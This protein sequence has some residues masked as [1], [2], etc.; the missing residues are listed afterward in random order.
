[1]RSMGHGQFLHFGL[2]HVALIA[3]SWWPSVTA[4]SGGQIRRMK[5]AF[6]AQDSDQKRE[7]GLRARSDGEGPQ[8]AQEGVPVRAENQLRKK[9]LQ[10]PDALCLDGSPGGYYFRPGHGAGVTK[11]TIYY[12]GGGWC[13]L[14][15][16]PWPPTK[17]CMAA[18]QEANEQVRGDCATR[19]RSRYGSSLD[20]YHPQVLTHSLARSPHHYTGNE[21]NSTITVASSDPAQNP[22]HDWNTVVVI[23]CVGSSW[24]SHVDGPV[25]AGPGGRERVFYRGHRINEALMEELMAFRSLGSATHVLVSGASAGGTA[26]LLHVDKW[27]E[28]LPRAQVRGFSLEPIFFHE[29]GGLPA[30]PGRMPP[31]HLGPEDAFAAPIYAEHLR[32]GVYERMNCSAGVPAACLAAQRASGGDQR[33]CILAQVVAKTVATPTVIVRSRYDT[34]ELQNTMAI[35]GVNPSRSRVEFSAEEKERASHQGRWVEQLLTGL[36]R[37]NSNLAYRLH[38]KACHCQLTHNVWNNTYRPALE[39]L[40]EPERPNGGS[41]ATPSRTVTFQTAK[42]FPDDGFCLPYERASSRMATHPGKL[43]VAFLAFALVTAVGCE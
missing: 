36:V 16:C 39:G 33:N 25:L 26:V 30:A 13:P 42:A 34:W 5:A 41:W 8:R 1:M 3:T 14:E 19:M 23:N 18:A 27:A 12:K 20:E 38:S 28:L 43:L 24:A 17:S 15:P 21:G 32:A 35:N 2:F 37:E 40:W 31:K 11:W 22:M 6:L 7:G 29:L 4:L 9:L 10:A